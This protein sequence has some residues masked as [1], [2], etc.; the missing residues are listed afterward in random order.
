MYVVRGQITDSPAIIESVYEDMCNYLVVRPV[1]IYVRKL[2]T[3]DLGEHSACKDTDEPI[4]QPYKGQYVVYHGM[5][6]NITIKG[7]QC[8]Q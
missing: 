8:K 5:R 2:P 7:L 3:S 4:W 1:I 6:V